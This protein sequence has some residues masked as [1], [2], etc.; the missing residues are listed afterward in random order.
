VLCG[1]ISGYNEKEPPPGPRNL[2]NLVLQRARMEGLIVIDHVARFGEG[3]AQLAK[4]VAAGEI[5]HREDI[6]D[7]FENA[8]ETFLRLF[9]GKNFGKQLLRVADPE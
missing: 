5:A 1:A 9:S 6:Q 7:G 4:W 8:P 3:A 2:M